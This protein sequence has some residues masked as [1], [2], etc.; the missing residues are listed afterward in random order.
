MA[1]AHLLLRQH[2][3]TKLLVLLCPKLRTMMVFFMLTEHEQIVAR[4]D[5][6]IHTLI[7]QTLEELINYC[8][9]SGKFSSSVRKESKSNLVFLSKGKR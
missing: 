4:L 3:L 5:G 6:H 8:M 2:I 9:N 1:A 7:S